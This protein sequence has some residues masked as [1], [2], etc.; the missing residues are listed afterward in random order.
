MMGG[1]SFLSFKLMVQFTAII[2]LGSVRVFIILLFYSSER[3]KSYTP[4]LDNYK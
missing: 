2:K 3:R 1:C 4:R